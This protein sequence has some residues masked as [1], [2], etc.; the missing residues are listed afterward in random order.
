M[1]NDLNEIID[2]ALMKDVEL[3][4]EEYKVKCEQ[5]DATAEFNGA[6]GA[7]PVDE[8]TRHKR[9]Q[10]NFYGTALNFLASILCEVSETNR[11]LG[12]LLKKEDNNGK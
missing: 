12:E 5:A 10:S 7:A 8:D 9:I 3:S 6:V 4:A 2:E 1:S 11:L